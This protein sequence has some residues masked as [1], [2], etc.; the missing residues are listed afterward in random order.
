MWSQSCLGEEYALLEDCTLAYCKTLAS[1]KPTEVKS[2]A[3]VCF[4][5]TTGSFQPKRIPA[6][7]HKRGRRVPELC[8]SQNPRAL[9]NAAMRL[10]RALLCLLL[11]YYIR[12]DDLDEEDL[13]DLDGEGDYE[14]P[15]SYIEYD[16][17]LYYDGPDDYYDGIEQFNMEDMADYPGEVSP[18]LLEK[19]F[20]ENPASGDELDALFEELGLGPEG[21]LYADDGYGEAFF[22]DEHPDQHKST[23][24]LVEPELGD[25]EEGLYERFGEGEDEL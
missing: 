16:Q 7:C 2:P 9:P 4:Y 18:E 1:S 19:I 8:S 24:K 25:V 13:F 14:D 15:E 11:R 20:G 3:A 10:R 17:A 23:V 21:V 12:A 6:A 22:D 5:N